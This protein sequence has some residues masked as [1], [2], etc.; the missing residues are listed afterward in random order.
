MVSTPKASLQYGLFNGSDEKR[1]DYI[2]ILVVKRQEVIVNSDIKCQHISTKAILSL[3]ETYAKTLLD[4]WF[5]FAVI[6]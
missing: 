6:C 3:A 2:G 4:K 5:G 1:K